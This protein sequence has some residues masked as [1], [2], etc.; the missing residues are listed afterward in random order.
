MKERGGS[1]LFPLRCSTKLP[2]PVYQK[3]REKGSGF[4]VVIKQGRLRNRNFFEL[5]AHY[6]L[7]LF[8][9]ECK[10]KSLNFR[11]FF[12]ESIEHFFN[13][14]LV[15]WILVCYN[16][17]CKQPKVLGAHFAGWRFAREG[18]REP[19]DSK[20]RAGPTPPRPKSLEVTHEQKVP[21]PVQGG[22]RRLRRRPDHHEEHSW[23]QGRRPG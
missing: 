3:A 11:Q 21:V 12:G 8:W 20:R 19:E 15:I 5:S 22:P 1:A 6:N 2:H 23:R 4:G 10:R 7:H 13:K 18:V 14:R 9:A 17:L 16:G